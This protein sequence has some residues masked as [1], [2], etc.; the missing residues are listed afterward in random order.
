MSDAIMS[1]DFWAKTESQA[2]A[3]LITASATDATL[4]I[5]NSSSDV[6]LAV[7]SYFPKTIPQCRTPNCW[8]APSMPADAVAFISTAIRNSSRDARTPLQ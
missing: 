5:I 2:V 3:D 8:A 6:E 7:D 1:E 4:G